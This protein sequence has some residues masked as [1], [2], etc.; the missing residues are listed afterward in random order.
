MLGFGTYKLT[1]AETADAVAFALK[2]GYR[3][4]DTAQMYRNEAEVGAGIR[5]SGIP[6]SQVF[7]ATKL[8]NAFHHYD[9]ALAAFDRSLTAL[10][11]DYVDLFLIHWPLPAL[12][13]YVEAWQAL[14]A[15]YAS[16]RARAIGVSNFQPHHVDK[17]LAATSVVPAVNQ[18][19]IHPYFTQPEL[20]AYDDSH[21]IITEAWSP[22]GRGRVLEDPVL[23]QIAAAHQVSAAQVVIRWHL[24]RGIVTIPKSAH[25]ERIAQNFDVFGFELT[26]D[27]MAAIT[28]LDRNMRTGSHPDQEN[29]TDR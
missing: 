20:V 23:A 17:L 7:V 28:A 2:T 12:D 21:Q 25:S 19:E 18:I 16:G 27:E 13:N 22:L 6:R 24:Q 14:E 9:D 5:A 11:M 8:N 26:D 4:I 1:P 10:G 29:R 15:I 3:H